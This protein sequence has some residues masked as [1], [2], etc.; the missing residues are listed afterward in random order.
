M[1][2]D[3]SNQ[4]IPAPLASTPTAPADA[5]PVTP[6]A[7]PLAAVTTETK[8]DTL[9]SLAI[10]ANALARAIWSGRGDDVSRLVADLLKGRDAA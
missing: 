7:I 1:H 6:T 5:A 9:E 3:A 2:T 4:P 8:P 10:D